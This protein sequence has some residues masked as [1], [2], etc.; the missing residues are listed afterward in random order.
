VPD[1]YLI[2]SLTA[3]EK[4]DHSSRRSTGNCGQNGLL[5]TTSQ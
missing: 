2:K 3:S 5:F 4:P 1:N